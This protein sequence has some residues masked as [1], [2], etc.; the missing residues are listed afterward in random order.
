MVISNAQGRNTLHGGGSLIDQTIYLSRICW[1]FLPEASSRCSSDNSQYNR[2]TLLFWL[3]AC[4]NAIGFLA[5]KKPQDRDERRWHN[6][7]FKAIDRFGEKLTLIANSTMHGLRA[8][9]KYE[10][11]VRNQM[12]AEYIALLHDFDK[13]HSVFLIRTANI[14]CE[15]FQRLGVRGIIDKYIS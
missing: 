15:S 3:R 1:S 13:K 2:L 8:D 11:E 5:N 10:Q 9:R 6:T 7:L 4:K 14:I 12:S